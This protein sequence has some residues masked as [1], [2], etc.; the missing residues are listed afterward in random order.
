MGTGPSDMGQLTIV[1]PTNET[2]TDRSAWSV[3]GL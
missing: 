3:L 2:S 1:T